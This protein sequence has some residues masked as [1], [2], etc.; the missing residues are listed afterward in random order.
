MLTGK[1]HIMKTKITSKVKIILCI[2]FVILVI[3][4]LYRA[5]TPVTTRR[6]A[7]LAR[8]SQLQITLEAYKT[9]NSYYPSSS[10][11]NEILA[12][13]LKE[14]PTPKTTDKIGMIFPFWTTCSSLD[15]NG[16]PIDAWGN[17][18]SI[19][20]NNIQYYKVYSLGPNGIDEKMGGDDIVA[21]Q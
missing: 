5:N 18:F 17:K 9:K 6:T 4:L 19:N 11:V 15:D 7:T 20:K 3:L 8:L 1:K 10:S 21:N 2:F 12:L 16:N 13:A 14:F